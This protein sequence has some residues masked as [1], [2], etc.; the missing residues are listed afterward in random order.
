MQSIGY[1]KPSIII[2]TPKH[3]EQYGNARRAR[4]IGVAET[5]HQRDISIDSLVKNIEYLLGNSSMD[6]LGN[7]NKDQRLDMGLERILE[8]L[9]G[10]IE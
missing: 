7:M 8:I 2:P 3:T 6:V 10:Y 4:E 5:L 9:S 1:L